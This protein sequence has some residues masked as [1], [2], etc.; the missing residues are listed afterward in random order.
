MVL[1]GACGGQRAPAR[2]P[3]PE[4]FAV[5]GPSATGTR[6]GTVTGSLGSARA[7][8]REGDVGRREATSLLTQYFT[9]L[10]PAEEAE[11]NGAG[12]VVIGQWTCGSDA[13]APLSAACSTEDDRQ[14]ATT[15]A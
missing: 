14:I 6:C 13:G 4:P 1:L 8:V 12:P 9:R 11:P 15:P 5:A 7:Y 3:Q 2:T 10:T